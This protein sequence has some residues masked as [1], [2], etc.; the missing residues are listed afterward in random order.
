MKANYLLQSCFWSGSQASGAFCK[1]MHIPVLTS[2]NQNCPQPHALVSH[3]QQR[4]DSSVSQET[5][6]KGSTCHML[7]WPSPSY[8]IVKGKGIKGC[9]YIGTAYLPTSFCLASLSPSQ[10]LQRYKLIRIQGRNKALLKNIKRL[11]L[12]LQDLSNIIIL[13]CCKREGNFFGP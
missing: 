2:A 11:K 10:N 7:C 5:K 13:S 12:L 8:G 6:S 4:G 3:Q 1:C 9:G